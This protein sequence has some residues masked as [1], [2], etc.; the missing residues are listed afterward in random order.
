MGLSAMVRK[1][2]LAHERTHLEKGDHWFKMIGFIAL[3][4]HWFNP[5]VWVAYI[6]LCKDIEMACD[7]RVVQFSRAAE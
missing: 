6:L 4:L 1:Y 3:A 7:E 2:I 5:L